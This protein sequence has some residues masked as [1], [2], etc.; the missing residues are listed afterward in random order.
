MIVENSIEE[1]RQ[2]QLMIWSLQEGIQIA[3]A[4]E[5][6]GER[7]KPAVFYYSPLTDARLVQQLTLAYPLKLMFRHYLMSFLIF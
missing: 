6:Q 1:E 5:E 4:S 2:V 7:Q 3:K